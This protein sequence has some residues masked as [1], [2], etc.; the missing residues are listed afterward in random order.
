[1]VIE[2]QQS[3]PVDEEA[4]A[5]ARDYLVRNAQAGSLLEAFLVSA[6]AAVLG[7][8]FFLGLT[9]YPQLGGAGLHI[10]HM[11]WGGLL[12]LVSVVI[13]LG[14]LSAPLTRLAAVIGG[15][16]F[17]AFIDELGKFVTSDNDYFFRPAVALIYAVF[18]VLFLAFRTLDVSRPLTR[19]EY[20]VNAL[21][22]IKELVREDLD[23]VEK[24][25]VDNYLSQG[26]PKDPLV[27]ALR[28]VLSRIQ[29]IPLRPPGLV[30]RIRR[31]LHS[32]YSDLIAWRWFGFGIIAFFTSYSVVTLS[33]ILV[34]SVAR[35]TLAETWASL[36]GNVPELAVLISSC[37]ATGCIAVGIVT[38]KW[39]RLRA[40]Q[41]F[42][43]AL[44]VSIF[45]TQFFSFYL[46]QL[47]AL[48]GFGLNVLTLEAIRYLIREEAN[49][50]LT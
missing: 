24:G 39:S 36:I 16:G 31:R 28:D 8:R 17:G 46:Q 48:L 45:F 14:F 10:A 41:M 33:Y 19:Q 37:L 6:A 22:L 5:L 30:G 2:R 21:E 42:R 29:P 1:M 23:E 35:P 32:F 26:D 3:L 13:L 44:L 50:T 20:V 40:Y 43:L 7:I 9:G 38:L 15:L 49:K 25:K 18:V 12:M 47:A 11:L 27:V 34:A 4:N